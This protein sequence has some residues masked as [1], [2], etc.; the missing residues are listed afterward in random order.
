[1][2]K[3]LLRLAVGVTVH[4][5]CLTILFFAKCF[6]YMSARCVIQTTTLKPLNE[7]TQLTLMLQQSAIPEWPVS[8]TLH[9]GI[10]KSVTYITLYRNSDKALA[11]SAPNKTQRA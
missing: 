3:Y 10:V 5:K 11:R 4:S 1:M 9:L 8:P 6:F 2:G 7:L